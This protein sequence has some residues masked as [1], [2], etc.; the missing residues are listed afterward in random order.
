M[1]LYSNRP[2]LSLMASILTMLAITACQTDDNINAIDYEQPA[3]H[4]LLMYLVGDYS[5]MSNPLENNAVSAQKAIRDSISAGKINLVIFKD[6]QKSGDNLPVLYW[7]HGNMKHGLD[8]VMIKQW[9]TEVDASD[10]TI[11]AEVVNTAFRKFDSKLKGIAFGSHSSG[12]VP[13]MNNN[14]SAR[15]PRRDS[16]G[17]DVDNPDNKYRTCELAELSEAL[18]SCPKLDYLIFDCCHMGNAE[19]AYQMRNVT[20]YM[21]AAPTEV[22][23]SGMPYANALTALAK[24]KDASDLPQALD[25]SIHCYFDNNKRTN[26]ATVALYDLQNMEQLANQYRSMILANNDR[27]KE[28]ANS[29]KNTL[30]QWQKDFQHFGRN[31]NG[32]HYYFYFYD[33]LDMADWLSTAQ[34]SGLKLVKEA[35]EQVVLKEYHANRFLDIDI[36]RCCGMAVTIPEVFALA[37]ENAYT[38]YFNNLGYS[39]LVT[40]YS[41]T[42]WGTFMGY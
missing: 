28:I 37:K 4:T 2:L 31:S 41:S 5:N 22:M 40:A 27:L 13:R 12:W 39:E 34:P 29:D 15:S 7:V 8:T 35:L 23:G 16:Y 42:D 26:G 6:N 36:E 3:D 14:A 17:L 33:L 38:S 11:I 1:M 30:Y 18:L 20:R 9:N 24:C 25:Y 19:V 32:V 21:T 10:P